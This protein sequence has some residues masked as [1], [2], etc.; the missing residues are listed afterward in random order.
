MKRLIIYIL[1]CVTGVLVA[2]LLARLLNYTDYIWCLISVILV[3][4]PDGK[5]A[6]M[7][8]TARMKA[9][10]IGAAS[11][12]IMLL[13]N[14]ATVIMV[15]GAV[16]ITIIAC[17]FLKL[18]NPTRSALAAS[19]I[20]T[21]HESGKHIWNV[22]LERIVAVVAGCI[23][24]LLITFAFHSRFIDRPAETAATEEG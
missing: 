14:P 23:L 12:M 24:G 18:E 7:L 19:I 15:A 9:N 3:L 4:S 20:V 17:Y 21:L 1:K 11:G 10:L 16:V 6:L 2:F 8:A 5:D 13:I 22:A